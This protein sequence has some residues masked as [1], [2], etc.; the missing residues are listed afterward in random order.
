MSLIHEVAANDTMDNYCGLHATFRCES[1][2]CSH[3]LHVQ[4]HHRA[5]RTRPYPT[6]WGLASVSQNIF[7]TPSPEPEPESGDDTEAPADAASGEKEVRFSEFVELLKQSPA[8]VVETITQGGFKQD[9]V[10]GASDE[11]NPEIQKLVGHT[12]DMV[13]SYL[14][15][16]PASTRSSALK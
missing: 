7:L 2:A 13:D 14:G 15:T 9:V 5:R 16:S 3:R 6:W 4:G 10:D 1:V 12:L 8:K 11:G